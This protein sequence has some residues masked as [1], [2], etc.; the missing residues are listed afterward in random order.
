MTIIRWRDR[1]AAFWRRIEV[2]VLTGL[3]L[4]VL[5]G[6]VFAASGC[7]FWR[8]AG[9]NQ[10]TGQPKIVEPAKPETGAAKVARLEGEL[11]KAKAEH[12]EERL[13]P[14]RTSLAWAEGIALLGMLAGVGLAVAA[15][16][17]TGMA[18]TWK[19]PASIAAGFAGILGFCFATSWALSH[20]AWIIAAVVA[21]VVLAFLWAVRR[22]LSLIGAAREAWNAVPPT[23]DLTSR[24]EQLLA[25]MEKV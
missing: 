24:A 15:Y 7:S 12:E 5:A 17:I 4:A 3:I 21:L 19:I 25:R 22:H 8:D 13:A 23:V 18:F 14:L 16:F 2:W 6:I 10:P 9:E 1:L 20:V 11:A